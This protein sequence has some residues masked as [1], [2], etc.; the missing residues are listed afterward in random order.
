MPYILMYKICP[1]GN[2]SSQVIWKM[3]TFIEED[4]KYK[5]HCI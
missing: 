2:V 3:E 1:A 4:T 5:K